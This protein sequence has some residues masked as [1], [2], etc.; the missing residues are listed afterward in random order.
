MGLEENIV[1]QAYL[2]LKNYIYYDNL[3]LFLKQRVAEFETESDLQSKFKEIKKCI[4]NIN[5]NEDN[6]FQKWLKQITFD[7]LPK[8]IN[9]C[10]PNTEKQQEGLFISNIREDESYS[11]SKINYFI[12]APLNYI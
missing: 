5:I 2:Y 12:N 9:T 3:N 8:Q 6:N 1:E 11:V 4:N 10:S 7:L